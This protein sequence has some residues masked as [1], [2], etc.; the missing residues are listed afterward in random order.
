M[1]DKRICEENKKI[2]RKLKLY[3]GVLGILIL[4]GLAAYALATPTLAAPT[5]PIVIDFENLNQ[6]TNLVGK[7]TS[8]SSKVI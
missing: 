3:K 6:N 8:K 2:G 7:K 5:A 4:L 1:K